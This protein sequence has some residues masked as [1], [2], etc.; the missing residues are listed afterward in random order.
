MAAPIVGDVLSDFTLPDS[1]G[2][3]QRLSALAAATPLVLVLYRGH[4]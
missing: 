4:W 1:L 2:A 3:P